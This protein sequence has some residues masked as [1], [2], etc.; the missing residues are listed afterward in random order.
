MKLLSLLIIKVSILMH[1]A[2]LPSFASVMIQPVDHTELGTPLSD[3]LVIIPR[4]ALKSKTDD[5]TKFNFSINLSRVYNI[6]ATE[7]LAEGYHYWRDGA[8]HEVSVP[9][10]FSQ[11]IIKGIIEQGNAKFTYISLDR[12][13]E[14]I[15][16]SKRAIEE[17]NAG[18]DVYEVMAK[19]INAQVYLDS[20]PQLGAVSNTPE[21]LTADHSN[22]TSWFSSKTFLI[23]AI[24]VVLLIVL[25]FFIRHRKT[26]AETTEE[27]ELVAIK[28]TPSKPI[29]PSSPGAPEASTSVPAEKS[30]SYYNVEAISSDTEARILGA[31]VKLEETTFFL[32]P[33][34]T[35]ARMSARMETNTKY[36]SH[37]I[38]SHRGKAIPTYINNLRINYVVKKL[39]ED[40][41]FRKYKISH[42]AALSGFSSHSKFSSEFKRVVGKSP[43]KFINKLNK[44]SDNKE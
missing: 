35:L 28:E 5:L 37:V 23:G 42:L 24:A 27:P 31:L 33:D 36:L 30:S 34:I 12:V 43:S 26:K 38:H 25:F 13:E 17:I 7:D 20:Q 8:W 18:A 4:V 6:R 3:G 32:N 11:N 14:C 19:L 1:F 9:V 21:A 41:V 44:K 10:D 22:A 40:P 15:L 2:T 29:T 16:F 39:E